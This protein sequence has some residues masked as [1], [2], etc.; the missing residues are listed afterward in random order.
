MVLPVALPLPCRVVGHEAA[1]AQLCVRLHVFGGDSPRGI[2]ERFGG[3]SL[4][5]SVMDFLCMFV[6]LV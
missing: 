1:A 4:L 6:G 2:Y 3:V 5:R